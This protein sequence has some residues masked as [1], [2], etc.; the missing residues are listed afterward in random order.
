[1]RLYIYLAENNTGVFFT[2]VKIKRSGYVF[3]GE[4]DMPITEPKKTVKREIFAMV[5]MSEQVDSYRVLY[6]VKPI[7]ISAKNIKITYDIEK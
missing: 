1:M 2:S 5:P 7:P 4:T 6:P 3:L